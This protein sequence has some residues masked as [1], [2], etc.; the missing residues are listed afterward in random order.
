MPRHVVDSTTTYTVGPGPA[1]QCSSISMLSPAAQPSVQRN[2]TISIISEHNDHSSH[3]PMAHSPWIT[4][5]DNY[6]PPQ[7]FSSINSDSGYASSGR[8]WTKSPTHSYVPSGVRMSANITENNA[9]STLLDP[10]LRGVYISRFA[11]ELAASLSQT[12]PAR[13]F[14]DIAAA[15]PSL[16]ERFTVRLGQDADIVVRYLSEYFT[17]ASRHQIIRIVTTTFERKAGEEGEDE[18]ELMS[19]I[20]MEDQFPLWQ[21]EAIFEDLS[22]FQEDLG[23]AIPRSS[24]YK[25]LF[26]SVLNEV[27]LET[28]GNE[29]ARTRIRQQILTTPNGQYSFHGQIVFQA[30][31]ISRFFGTQHVALESM[32]VLTGTS[33]QACASTCLEYVQS[34]WS[35]F[36]VQVL[37]LHK[38][39]LSLGAGQSILFDHT[40][41]LAKISPGGSIYTVS[42]RGN[43]LSIV[44]VIGQLVWLNTSMSSLALNK[45]IVCQ[46]PSCEVF[47]QPLVPPTTDT[48]RICWPTCAALEVVHTPAGRASAGDCWTNLFNN[49]ILVK[50]YP[51]PRRLDRESEL[52]ISLVMIANLANAKKISIF[53]GRILIKGYSTVLVPTKQHQNFVFWHIVF[54][55]DGSHLS[56]SDSR[57][58]EL[59]KEYPKD[60][61]IGDLETA[62]HILGWCATVKN[63]AGT[64]DANYDIGWSRL[65]RPGPG[66]AFEKI[67][68]AGG[69]FVTGSVSAAIGKKDKAVHIKSRDDYT[70]RLKWIAK[71]FVVLYDVQERRA[72][73]VDGASALLHLVRASLKHDSSDPFR[74]LFLYDEP[75]LQEAPQPHTGKTASISVL[76]N[77]ENMKLPLYAKPDSSRED[78]NVNEAGARSSIISSTKMNYCLKDRIESICDVLEQIMAHQ[79]DMSTQ[80]GV[81]FKIKYSTRRQLEGFDFMDVATD[82]DLL[83]SRVITLRASGR[84]WVDFTRAIHAVSLFGTGFGDLIQPVKEGVAKCTNCRANAEVPK[85]QDYLTIC[86]SELQ[87]ILQKQG[88]DNTNPWR[89]VDDIYWHAPD[90]TF[91]SCHCTKLNPSKHDR[92]Q[93]LLPATFPKLWGRGFK[94]PSDLLMTPRGALLFGHS[95]RFPLK[96]SDQGIPEEGH[97]NSGELEE[98]EVSFHDSAIGTS[99]GSSGAS[100]TNGDSSDSPGSNTLSERRGRALGITADRGL[101]SYQEK[102]AV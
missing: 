82:E 46:Y 69:M 94:S 84:G 18:L 48:F 27:K 42:M 19:K 62:R 11:V 36:G 91:E 33:H 59:F 75:A 38:H 41:L 61:T 89:L 51:I 92:V 55:E 39:L 37:N 66:C 20:P 95:W 93:V 45:G 68:I 63:R 21:S 9:S 22:V 86:V 50:G 56:Y 85:G 88:S 58:K 77:N 8:T 87:D 60:L 5:P 23:I 17:P 102:K 35:D 80:D 40:Q 31:W 6:I 2:S 3:F 96:W 71:K 73:L 25:S 49:P 32:I 90:K 7:S 98:M 52:E 100:A 47:T 43:A 83:W 57:V 34:V 10:S 70:M 54:N 76:A 24:A 53:S 72:W 12:V 44:E 1:P 28:L 29:D 78:I 30:P 79:A 81:G 67:T 101:A 99:P 14:L 65:K 15:L 26:D 64:H 4:I 74:S 13:R 16:L 97:P